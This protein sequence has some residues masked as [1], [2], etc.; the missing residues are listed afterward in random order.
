[1]RSDYIAARADAGTRYCPAVMGAVLDVDARPDRVATLCP[2]A[3]I[4]SSWMRRRM[5]LHC[6]TSR[7]MKSLLPDGEKRNV[8]G[9][10]KEVILASVIRLHAILAQLLSARGKWSG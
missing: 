6:A 3:D 10:G 1:M 9:V 4:S 7:Y 5:Y 2:H 8:D